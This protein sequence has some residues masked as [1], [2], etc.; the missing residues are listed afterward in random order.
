[1]T[2]K[3]VDHEWKLSKDQIDLIEN[4]E[5]DYNSIDRFLRKNVGEDKQT[6]FMVLVSEYSHRHAGWRDADLLRTVAEL[7]N[8]IVHG[9]TE[10][11]HYVAVPT[12]AIAENLK[13]CRDRLMNPARA[14][15]HFSGRWRQSPLMT[16]WRK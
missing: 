1:M 10:P 6:S 3:A 9:K 8:S 12:P 5:A 11:Y 16:L 15:P 2:M 7:R 4:F 13:A 14:I